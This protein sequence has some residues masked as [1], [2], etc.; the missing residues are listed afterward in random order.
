VSAA[1][2]KETEEGSLAS[3]E[4]LQQRA[5]IG[6]EVLSISNNSAE[7]TTTELCQGGGSGIGTT[8]RRGHV[9][10]YVARDTD[11]CIV[12]GMQ[13]LVGLGISDRNRHNTELPINVLKEVEENKRRRCEDIL[14][15][16]GKIEGENQCQQLIQLTLQESAPTRLGA[17][18]S[19]HLFNNQ[20]NK[21][22][23]YQL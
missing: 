8:Y 16:S 19:I 9:S 5:T 7:W 20:F 22:Q 17:S 4:I 18:Q 13:D 3:L 11:E 15:R 10:E 6:H 1:A 14:A 12:K 21:Q 2:S 23:P